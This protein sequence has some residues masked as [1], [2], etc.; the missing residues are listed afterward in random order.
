MQGVKI[1]Q[2][3]PNPDVNT[4]NTGDNSGGNTDIEQINDNSSENKNEEIPV[5]PDAQPNAPIE[6]PP[7]TQ[8]PPIN[9]NSND[10]KMIV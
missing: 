10:P 5:P 1:M 2:N 8:K 9:E 7:D 6:E 4:P 3:T